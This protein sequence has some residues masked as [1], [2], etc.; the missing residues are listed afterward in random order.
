MNI[1]NKILIS[2]FQFILLFSITCNSI[3]E[4]IID[5]DHSHSHHDS[6]I[7]IHQHN[8]S[9]ITHSHSHGSIF[10]LVLDYLHLLSFS[11]KNFEI[12]KNED[13]FELKNLY[14]QEVINKLLNPPKF[15]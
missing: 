9:S 15:S 13:N 5:N 14:S 3:Q 1:Q 4:S 6:I 2:L 12:S 7:H 11:D 10:I 8:H